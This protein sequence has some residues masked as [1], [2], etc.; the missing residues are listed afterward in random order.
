MNFRVDRVVTVGLKIGPIPVLTPNQQ[1]K[2]FQPFDF[3]LNGTYGATSPAFN[4]TKVALRSGHTPKDPKDFG[5]NF[6]RQ[7]F[8]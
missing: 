6:G 7:N 8:S 5:A 3:L 1:P 2:L 4:F